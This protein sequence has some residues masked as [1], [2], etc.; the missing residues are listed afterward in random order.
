[1]REAWNCRSGMESSGRSKPNKSRRCRLR[2]F[3]MRVTV[4]LF[5]VL[6]DLAGRPAMATKR[7]H[8]LARRAR[9]RWRI[10]S[11]AILHRSG[12]VALGEPSVLIAVACPHRAEAFEAC[13]WLI[14]TLK[15][16]VAIWKKEVWSDGTGTW[17]EGT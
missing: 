2:I 13:R 16:E 5:A 10:V 1:M 8:E 3:Q 14:D 9:E 7:M 11:L 15:A 4:K 17:V 6:K 12:R